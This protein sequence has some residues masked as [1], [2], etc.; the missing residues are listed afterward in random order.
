M[1]ENPSYEELRRRV[2]EL[3]ET[4]RESTERYRLLAENVS[5]VI[6]IRDMNL[7]FTYISPSVERLTGN[8]RPSCELIC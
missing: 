8:R 7:R 4:L 2:D 3:E 6:F 1:I 5:D